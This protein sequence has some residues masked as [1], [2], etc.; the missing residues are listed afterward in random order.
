MYELNHMCLQLDCN[1]KSMKNP[2]FVVKRESRFVRKYTK[3][4]LCCSSG[5][6][7][8]IMTEREGMARKSINDD[9]NDVDV[10]DETTV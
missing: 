10:D 9:D 8:M 4:T 1:E 7:A 6:A 2:T 5:S 3:H